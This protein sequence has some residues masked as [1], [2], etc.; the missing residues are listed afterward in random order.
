MKIT[1]LEQYLRAAGQ[2]VETLTGADQQVYMVVKDTELPHGG[3]QGKR[4]DIAILRT[5]AEP[6]VA[7]AAIHTY[8]ALVP[9]V[10]QDPLKTQPSSIGP[11]WQYWS[12]R[13][14]RPCTPQN[15]WAHI[16]TTLCDPRWQPA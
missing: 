3:L 14:D 2:R 11:G 16:L 15:L 12:R 13:F 5:E 1:D 7:P 4:C 10:W 9:M 6:Y 8:P